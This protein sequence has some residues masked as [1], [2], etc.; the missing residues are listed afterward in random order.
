MKGARQPVFPMGF[1]GM[2][3]GLLYFPVIFKVLLPVQDFLDKF[4]W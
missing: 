4:N 2:Y 3:L 1:I